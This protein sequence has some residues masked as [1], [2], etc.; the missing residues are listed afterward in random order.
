M[1]SSLS[2]SV[3]NL[4]DINDSFALGTLNVAYTGEN[5]NQTAISKEAFEKSAW[6][7]LNCPIVANYDFETK[8]IGGHDT[9][10][11]L[12]PNGASVINLTQPVGVVPESAKFYWKSIEDNGVVHDY[13]CIDN[14]ILW[15]RQPCYQKLVENGTT[16][17]SIEISVTN[18]QLDDGILHINEFQFEAF[19]LLERDEPCFEQASLQLFSKQEFAEQWQQMLQEYAQTTLPDSENGGKSV[20]LEN[21]VIQEVED[22][23]EE[24]VV[25]PA[26]DG[27]QNDVD[28][29]E[30]SA[31]EEVVATSEETSE[32]ETTENK[33]S[34]GELPVDDE[35]VESEG[36]EVPESFALTAEQIRCQLLRELDVMGNH[37]SL[38]DYDNEN[39]YFY[40]CEDGLLY[41]CAYQI[42]DG[43]AVINLET[44]TRKQLA[45]VDVEQSES[46]SVLSDLINHMVDEQVGNCSAAYADKIAQ[47][48]TQIG[49]LN[50][51]I[52]EL[53]EFKT[54]KLADERA[55]AETAL[56]DRFDEQLQRCDAYTELKQHAAEYSLSE[57]ETQCYVLVAKK[58][59]MFSKAPV[60]RRIP[61]EGVTNT[62]VD[63]YGG[64]L[65]DKKQI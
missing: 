31:D 36:A 46:H 54:Q 17:Q 19:C 3:S 11:S 6:S 27:A 28:V 35:T 30:Q 21:T 43:H 25:A 33:T 61:V 40:D 34:D 8:E 14:V 20:D 15:K 1:K 7:A 32:V 13:L 22:I 23:A 56:F 49:E 58:A 38:Y 50:A 65:N 45:I 47:L 26:D 39:V 51:T 44:K 18:G 52:K 55:S 5:R 63:A 64:L 2:N 48:E 41:G 57:L 59:M 53:T 37:F 60:S 9:I 16:A 10:L 12:S 62:S 4:T 42:V 29:A 24:T